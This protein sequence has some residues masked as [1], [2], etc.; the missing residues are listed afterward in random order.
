M[1]PCDP[2]YWMPYNHDITVALRQGVN[3]IVV[4]LIRRTAT[5]DFSLGYAVPKTHVRWI[6]D[7]MT[8]KTLI[9]AVP[10]AA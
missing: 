4:K 7:L 1:N 10:P 9:A 8:A 6:N 3:R 2:W 5:C